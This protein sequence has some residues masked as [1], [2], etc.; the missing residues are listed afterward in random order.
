MIYTK[1]NMIDKIKAEIERRMKNPYITFHARNE[2]LNLLSFIESLEKDTIKVRPKGAWMCSNCKCYAAELEIVGD[3]IEVPG[4]DDEFEISIESLEEEQSTMP[5]ST[6]LIAKWEETKKM[7]EE[8]D[9]RGD[10][11]R[12][13]YNAFLEGFAKGVKVK[14]PRDCGKGIHK[15]EYTGCDISWMDEYQRIEMFVKEYFQGLWPG[16][17]TAEQCNTDMHFTPP[18]IMRLAKHFYELGAK[19]MAEKG[20][21]AE[22]EI[23]CAVAHPHENKVIARVNG[24]YKFG[25]K[26]IVQI[27]RKED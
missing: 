6:E 15:Q 23:V 14:E 8:K 27:R 2:L 3:A 22:G 10:A 19:W 11:W 25:D 13:A 26:V 16:T 21:T 17:E 5:N 12:L 24:D 4:L 1:R 20:E 9:F 18:A 7:L